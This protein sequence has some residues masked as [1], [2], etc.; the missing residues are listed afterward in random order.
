MLSIFYGEPQNENYIFDPNTF[1]DHT[2]ED[3]WILDSL[4]RE[5]I[6]DIDRSEVVGPHLIESPFL[7]PIPTEKLSGGV[8]TLM[9]IRFDQEHLFNASACGDNCAKWLLQIGKEKD[10]LIRLGYLMDFGDEA[11]EICVANTGK[12]VHSLAELDDEVIGNGLLK[13]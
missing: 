2:F 3:E 6:R 11:F 5:M 8:K 9:L 10:I 1:F 12:I 13:G 4:S 7:G